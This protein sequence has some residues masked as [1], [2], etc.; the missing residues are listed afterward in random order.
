[1][2]ENE[3]CLEWCPVSF[4]YLR[5]KTVARTADFPADRTVCCEFCGSEFGPG[6]KQRKIA[7]HERETD[8]WICEKC[9]GVFK[10]IYALAVAGEDENP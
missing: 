3:S 4:E 10:D 1:M 2:E 8:S 9:L 6:E 7:Y 5:G